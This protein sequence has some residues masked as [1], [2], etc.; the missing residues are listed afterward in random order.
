VKESHKDFYKQIE[1]NETKEE[2]EEIETTLIEKKFTQVSKF[3]KR[4]EKQ[5]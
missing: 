4:G 5:K 2:E 3:E 1:S